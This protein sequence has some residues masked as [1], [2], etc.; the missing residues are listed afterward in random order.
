MLDEISLGLAPAV[1]KQL[2]QAIPRI[3][4]DGTTLVIVEQDVTQALR[5]ADRAYC[6]LEGR[7]SLQGEPSQ[8]TRD[9]IRAAYFGI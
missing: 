7:V 9:D 4:D 5:V 2:Y 6:F 1:V 8:L 3:R